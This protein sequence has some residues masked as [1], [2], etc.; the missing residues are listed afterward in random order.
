MDTAYTVGDLIAEFLVKCHV[1][2]AF[3][4]VSVHNVPMLDAIA[5]GGQI[6]F[7]MARGELGGSH[8]ADGYARASD[9]LG[10]LF[11][12]TGPG[13]SNAATGIVEARFAGSPLL[14]FTGQTRTQYVDRDM[15]C[16]HE[17]PDQLG[18]MGSAGKAALRIRHPAD[19]FAVLRQAVASALA[20]PSGPVT[21]EVPIDVQSMAL[22]RP[23]GLDLYRLPEPAHPRPSD[24]ELDA[25]VEQVAQARRPMLWLGRGAL[26]AGRQ[27][28]QLLDMGFGMVTSQAGR[29]VVP[30]QHPMNLGTLNLG[31]DV[32]EQFYETVDLMIVAGSRLRGYETADFT[33][34][35]PRRLVQVDLDP[36]ADGRTYA[37]VGFVHGDVGDVLDALIERLRGR[38]AVDPQ[39]RADFARLKTVARASYQASLGPYATLAEQLQPLL[40]DDAIW[41]RD[42]TMNN[43]TWGNRL[44]QLNPGI[45]NIYPI[46][47]GIGQG[48]CLGIGAALAPG[49]RKTLILI[50]DGGLALNLGELWT[51]IQERL[52]VVLIVGNDNGYG[53]IR[54]IQDKVAGGRRVYDDLLSPDMKE[55]ARLAGM[56]F[57][58]V[59]RAGDF[60]AAMAEAIAVRGPT[61]VE[62]DMVAIGVFPPYYPIGPKVAT[63]AVA[64]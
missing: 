17:I 19:A 35:L 58:R 57:W 30:D 5:R 22:A 3:G 1:D 46:S 39:F 37:N 11:T 56:P 38:L 9:R 43:S 29:G 27:V 26:A 7:V 32:V 51:A 18:L 36:R 48:M 40:P 23:A 59:A 63:V 44:L 61:M 31:L 4:V 49:G 33:A 24:A 54:Q 64:P 50:G 2:T 16:V 55:L 14:H 41:A 10:V 42:I 20:F 8:M 34:P 21:I 28:S 62:I 13:V 25:L 52:D 45:S 12:S 47:G 6:R 60:G 15:G 53:V